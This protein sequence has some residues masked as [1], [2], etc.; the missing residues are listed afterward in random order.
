[1]WVGSVAIP[2][3]THGGTWRVNTLGLGDADGNYEYWSGREL[4]GL[5]YPTTL[6]VG[7]RPDDTAPELVH[8]TV[9]PR[10]VDPRT[11][12]RTVTVTARGTDDRSGLASLVVSAGR[13]GTRDRSFTALS[14]VPRTASTYR[15]TLV[16]PGRRAHGTWRIDAVRLE[17]AIGN[18]TVMSH[19]RLREAG[20]T[21]TFRLGGRRHSAGAGP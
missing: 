20:F 21:R 12:A 2:R 11:G 18:T 19:E 9:A 14:G 15:G 17:D 5:G 6:T 13:P 1:M 10:R 3:W 8:L 16:I 7:A 4:A